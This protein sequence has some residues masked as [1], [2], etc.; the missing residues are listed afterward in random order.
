MRL[1]ALAAAAVV[2]L[3]GCSS[4]GVGA[5]QGP[6]A[7]EAP[8]VLE[9]T[10]PLPGVG[11][12][13]SGA[14]GIMGRFDHFGWDPA[15][16]RLFVAAVANGSLE[17]I[18]LDKGERIRSIS[19]LDHAQGVAVAMSTG[20]VIVTC[21]ELNAFFAIDA[22]T[23]EQK[24]KIEIGADPDNVRY[25]GDKHYVGYGNERSGAIA[26]IDPSTLKTVARV[27]LPA[28]PESFQLTPDGGRVF[29]NVPWTKQADVEGSVIAADFRDATA[30][31]TWVL[32]QTSRNFPM[33]LDA[34]NKRLF[35]AARKPAKLLC[36]SAVTGKILGETACIDDADDVFWD[37]QTERVIVIGG[38][39][40]ERADS[41][42]A[43]ELYA[44]AADG[45]LK[46]AATL[47][48]APRARTGFF[49]AA[50]RRLYVAVPQRPG[51]DAEV[52]EYALGE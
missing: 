12:G 47:P 35:I 9:R 37:A 46:Q 51:H 22:K 19:G 49:L 41:A 14:A 45:T 26:C 36:L 27:P 32:P 3:F 34:E 18:D 23:L 33:A 39:A 6:A 11:G 13:A 29:V 44:V 7:A 43:V 16:N 17:V 24:A 31:E 1:L 10:I 30:R 4:K 21:G 8:I 20:Q 52:R 15:T 48:T 50:T 40:P 42:G 38:G 2:I 28:H 25:V 5:A